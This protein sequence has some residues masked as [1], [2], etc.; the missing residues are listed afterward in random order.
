[1]ILLATAKHWGWGWRRG[2]KWTAIERIDG[3][4]WHCKRYNDEQ[5]C[6]VEIGGA[7]DTDFFLTKLHIEQHGLVRLGPRKVDA[8]LNTLIGSDTILQGAFIEAVAGELR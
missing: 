2:I 6:A 8:M 4:V 7:S 1:M 5:T 3:R